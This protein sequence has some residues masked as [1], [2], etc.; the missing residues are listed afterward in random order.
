M[1]KLLIIF[2]VLFLVLGCSKISEDRT[3][4]KTYLTTQG[5][6]CTDTA[7]NLSSQSEN[8]T[9]VIFTNINF[10]EKVMTYA[11]VVNDTNSIFIN[12]EYTNNKTYSS[13]KI[14]D[15]DIS[16]TYEF[17]S[18]TFTCNYEDEVVCSNI[19]NLIETSKDTFDN[20]V[21][22]ADINKDNL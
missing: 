14:S 20:Y 11:L 5:Y 21:K 17:D 18:N 19:K 1:K 7:C 4:F 22:S 8:G 3:T 10:D 2:V 9:S 16:S 13:Y 15:Y 6:D 12:Y